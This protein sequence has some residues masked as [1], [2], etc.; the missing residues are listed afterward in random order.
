[1]LV[2]KTKRSGLRVGV[3]MEHLIDCP[4]PVRAE[5]RSFTDGGVDTAATALAPGQKLR[6]VKFVAYAWAGVRSLTA[7][8]DQVWAALTAA[9]A[10]RLRQAAHRPAPVPERLLRPR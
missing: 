7:V 1:V 6:V 5:S 10:G 3:A 8:R 4:A 2:H 9:A